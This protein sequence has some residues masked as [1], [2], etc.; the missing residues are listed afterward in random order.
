MDNKALT[1]ECRAKINLSL[2]VTGRRDNGYHDVELIFCEIPLCDKLTVSLCEEPEI[3]L[4]CDDES[5]PIDEN[6]IAY[7]AAQLFFE[8]AKAECGANIVLEKRIPHGAGLGGGSS[9]AA[10]VLKA[11]NILT[12]SNFSDEELMKLGT[13]L[14][15]DVSFFIKGGCALAEGI[16]EILTPLPECEGFIYILAKPKESV[17]TKWVYENLDLENRPPQLCVQAVAEGVRRGDTEMIY[18][19]S[20]NILESVTTIKVPIINDIKDCFKLCGAKI[21]LMSGSGTT[22]FGV[23]EDAEEA[24]NAANEVK[25]FTDEVYLI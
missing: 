13:R 3:Y 19:N 10:G 22:V 8:A 24:R 12:E 9:D 11:L 14:G 7:R 18:N 16:G 25:K 1:I 6:N 5:L 15:A 17:S 23:F 4:S 20:G 2:D 21:S